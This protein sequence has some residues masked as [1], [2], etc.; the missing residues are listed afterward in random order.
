MPSTRPMAAEDGNR[1]DD[2]QDTRQPGHD[3]DELAGPEWLLDKDKMRQYCHHQ[4][5]SRLQHGDQRTVDPAD[6]HCGQYIS[7]PPVGGA[8]NEHVTDGFPG[9]AGATAVATRG[10]GRHNA[11]HTSS[12]DMAINPR[13]AAKAKGYIDPVISFTKTKLLPHVPEITNRFVHSVAADTF[14]MVNGGSSSA[15]AVKESHR[16]TL[17]PDIA[18]TTANPAIAKWFHC[19]W[20][21]SLMRDRRMV[22]SALKWRWARTEDDAARAG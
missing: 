5:N 13:D 14:P 7:K 15:V 18:V 22:I 20:G 12:A 6:C 17:N 21:G 1:P 19:G 4:R 11:S 16:G 2:Q 8:E 10:P 9:M 3:A